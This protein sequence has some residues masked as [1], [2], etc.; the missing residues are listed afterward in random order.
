MS[1]DP[2]HPSRPLTAASAAVSLAIVSLTY[3]PAQ[4]RYVSEIRT[5]PWETLQPGR[6]AP[7]TPLA[8]VPTTQTPLPESQPHVVTP[9]TTLPQASG[10]TTPVP[11]HVLPVSSETPFHTPRSNNPFDDDPEETGVTPSRHAR[12]LFHE[13]SGAS[14]VLHP[15]PPPFVDRTPLHPLPVMSNSGHNQNPQGQFGA[16]VT[17]QSHE[18]PADSEHSRRLRAAQ[19]V[20]RAQ[21]RQPPPVAIPEQR[22]PQPVPPAT[23]PMAGNWVDVNA[24]VEHTLASHLSSLNVE[25]LRAEVVQLED[26]LAGRL[27]KERNLNKLSST[28]HALQAYIDCQLEEIRRTMPPQPTEGL[29]DGELQMNY[30]NSPIN[31]IVPEQFQAPAGTGQLNSDLPEFAAVQQ[32]HA[33][34]AQSTVPDNKSI[35]KAL[36]SLRR[37]IKRKRNRRI[38]SGTDTDASPASHSE[39]DDDVPLSHWDTAKGPPAPGL[40][41]IIPYDIRFKDVLS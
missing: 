18:N 27:T 32:A 16:P 29:L 41:E 5:T 39:D 4:I 9:A 23:F 35:S 2:A 34:T 33:D 24:H 19:K 8:E 17:S 12:T 3:E 30:N 36:H 10:L 20:V 1:P 38:G 31:T 6:T 26:R 37:E 40:K 28:T 13:A 25:G 14:S 15:A 11:G 22:V 21:P 7:T